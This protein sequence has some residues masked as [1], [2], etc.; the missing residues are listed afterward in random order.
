M[1]TIITIAVALYLIGM[2]VLVYF[3]FKT[4]DNKNDCKVDGKAE[5][6]LLNE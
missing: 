5:K 4:K 3:I 6:S 2:G 1:G